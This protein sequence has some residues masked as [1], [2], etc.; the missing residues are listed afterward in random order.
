MFYNKE[1]IQFI[2]EGLNAGKTYTDII[3]EYHEEL[4][5]QDEYHCIYECALENMRSYSVLKTIYY[6]ITKK[7]QPVTLKPCTDCLST[8]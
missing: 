4:N 3:N 8:T 1:E 5:A 2:I 7:K 6:A